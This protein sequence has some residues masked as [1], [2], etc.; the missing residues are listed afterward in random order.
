[1]KFTTRQLMAAA[2]FA[3]AAPA[4]GVAGPKDDILVIGDSM[5]EWQSFKRA[6]IPHVLAKETKRRVENRAA[7]GA[8]L[9]L[10]GA[11]GNSRSVIP[12]QY[13]KGDWNW[14]VVN[15]GANDL[16]VKCGC[17]RC[18]KVLDKLIT[19]DGK[20]GILP[21]LAAR[22]RKDGPK[23]ILLAYYEGNQRPNLFSRCER[24]V[25]ELT[26]RQRAL[27]ARLEGVELVRSKPAINPANRSHFALDGVH[28]SR[29]GA[30]RVGI[31]LARSLEQLEARRPRR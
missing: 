9:Y 10:T 21:D 30:R 22:I 4:M 25:R 27:A 14:V 11:Q 5:L 17:N 18:N 3:L 6:S 29:K 24:V 2:C 28:L 13:T 16:L 19:K 31:L 20:A 1:M 15:G 26:D 8:K 12:A 7:S 23:V